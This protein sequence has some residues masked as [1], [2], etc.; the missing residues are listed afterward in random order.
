MKKTILAIAVIMT[1]A[2]TACGG[3]KQAEQAQAS[4]TPVVAPEQADAF[5]GRYICSAKD[6]IEIEALLKEAVEKKPGN[7]MLFFARKLLGRPYVAHTLET[8]G[9]EQLVVNM[10]EFDC[11][12]YAETCEALTICAAKGLTTLNDYLKTLRTLRY[13]D[14]KIQ[15]YASRLHY[16]TDRTE[17]NVKKQLVKEVQ[18]PN[19]PFT[20]IQ[21]I[22]LHFMTA[23]PQY[24]KQL[25]ENP[26]LIPLIRQNEEKMNGKKYR[27]IPKSLI[28]NNALMKKQ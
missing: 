17:E 2:G 5:D 6:S 16:F 3:K 8:P 12:T 14:G 18:G 20:A 25:K 4:N 10:K 28:G 13:Y 26:E 15:N 22:D 19:P 9:E 21:T 1:T 7:K 27:Y 24:Y 11:T 23:N